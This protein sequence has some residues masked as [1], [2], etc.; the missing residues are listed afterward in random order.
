MVEESRWLGSSA[1]TDAEAAGSEKLEESPQVK[2]QLRD[3]S[4]EIVR[5]VAIEQ[6]MG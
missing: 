1:L 3:G 5:T 4:R 6:S 2:R